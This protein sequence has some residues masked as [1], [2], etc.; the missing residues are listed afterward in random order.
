MKKNVNYWVG[1]WTPAVGLELS[2]SSKQGSKHGLLLSGLQHGLVPL[3]H[4]CL[5]IASTSLMNKDYVLALLFFM[6]NS[7][8]A[9][10]A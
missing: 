5:R 2:E 4:E 6:G 9:L 10:D 7:C 8:S 1:E 3:N